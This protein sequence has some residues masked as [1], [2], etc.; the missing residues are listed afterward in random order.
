MTD[1]INN[2]PNLKYGPGIAISPYQQTLNKME[3]Q[4]RQQMIDAGLVQNPNG[5]WSYPKEKKTK[6]QELADIIKGKE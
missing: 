2:N 6:E 3:A 4:Q 1:Y 5:S